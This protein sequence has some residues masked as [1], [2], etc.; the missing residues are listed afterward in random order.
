MLKVSLITICYNSEKTIS[1]T[2]E[3]ILSQ[4]YENIEYIIIDGNSSDST[5]S[6]VNNYKDK[7]FKVVSEED[8]GLYDALNKGANFATGDVVGFLH[9]D[10]F[11]SNE[12]VIS[13]M[14][15]IFS[16]NNKLDIV[17]GDVLFI[18]NQ[19]NTSRFY[20]GK[21]FDFDCGIMPPHPSVFIKR[22][23]YEKFGYF[24]TNYKI[25][26]DYDLLFRFIV[27]KNMEY[28]YSKNILVYM[29]L[30]GVSTKNIFSSITLNMEIYKIHKAHQ[31]P[32][33][34]LKLLQKI[35]IRIKEL[36]SK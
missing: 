25:A 24:N 31:H 17:L 29:T 9:A 23:C 32:I 8:E 35:P 15:K 4:D 1:R 19:G 16:G 12:N 22:R 7:I 33:N 34:L 3:S 36:L 18:N 28:E 13:N 6:I 27:L 2:I 30:G 10:D 21:N 26:S 14:I 11:Y 20:S 5:I